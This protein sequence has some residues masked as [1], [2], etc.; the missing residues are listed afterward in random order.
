MSLGCVLQIQVEVSCRRWLRK[1]VVHGRG[2]GGDI[3]TQATSIPVAL[4][5]WGLDELAKGG[6]LACTQGVLTCGSE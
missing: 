5:A 4:K 3:N 2:L 6:V 1:P